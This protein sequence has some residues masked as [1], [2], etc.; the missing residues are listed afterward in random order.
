MDDMSEE[1]IME[2]SKKMLQRSAAETTEMMG[3]DMVRLLDVTNILD[4]VDH[5]QFEEALV[6]VAEYRHRSLKN[7][8]HRFDAVLDLLCGK[9]IP[10]QHRNSVSNYLAGMINGGH[11]SNE[12]IDTCLETVNREA[13]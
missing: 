12:Q 11:L 4:M 7:I 1:D 2:I 6:C 8:A 5:P 9:P 3:Q 10:T 13:L